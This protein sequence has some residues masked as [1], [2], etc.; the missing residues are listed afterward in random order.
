M[1]S[2]ITLQNFKCFHSI[3]I[4]PKL[5]TVFIG[6]NGTG[7]SGVLQ[8]LLLLKQSRTQVAPLVMDGGLIRF[9]TESFMLQGHESGSNSVQ[10]SLS[11]Y[12]TI[13]SGEI[14]GPLVI[15]IDL[16]YSEQAS[17]EVDRGST[18]WESSGRQYEINFHR[19]G[20]SFE[21]ETQGGSI[22]Y[23]VLPHV[24]SFRVAYGSGGEKPNRPL[25]RQISQA[26]SNMLAELRVVPAARG[27]NPLLLQIGR[28]LFRRHFR[29]QRPRCSRGRHR[30]D[31]GL[32]PA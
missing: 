4:D 13:D 26:P 21:T 32:F 24:N 6:P 19:D 25:W 5:I 12:S 27:L 14:Q 3:S 8:A 15:K 16:Q 29:S 7:K 2:N 9:A 17:L 30:N 11:G 10:L 20:R 28:E 31:P 18:K 1:I 23:E 22:R